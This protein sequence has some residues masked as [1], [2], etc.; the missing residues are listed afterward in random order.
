MYFK[1]FRLVCLDRGSHDRRIDGEGQVLT[2]LDKDLGADLR[3]GVF[4]V[5][6]VLE[7]QSGL[8]VVVV[9]DLDFVLLRSKCH[10]SPL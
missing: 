8:V 4:A 3:Q 5:L 7:H 9:N 2:V 6:A 10:R 1:A